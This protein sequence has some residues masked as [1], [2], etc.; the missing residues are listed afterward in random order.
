[1]YA[2]NK[3][4]HSA[5]KSPTTSQDEIAPMINSLAPDQRKK[6]PGLALCFTCKYCWAVH[7]VDPYTFLFVF[8][9]Q[10][11]SFGSIK[12]LTPHIVHKTAMSLM[13]SA[14]HSAL[15]HGV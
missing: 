1:M 7:P 10:E 13:H 12:D 4:A 3:I 2:C 9:F 15:H 14:L 8:D 11:N 6:F 5:V